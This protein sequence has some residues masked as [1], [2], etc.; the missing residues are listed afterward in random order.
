MAQNKNS[1]EIPHD[2]EVQPPR[3]GIP[4]T[5]SNKT[6]DWAK[7]IAMVLLPAF[8]ALYFGLAPF[9]ELPKAEA[10][11][12]TIVLLDAFIGTVLQI[13]NSR[14]NAQESFDGNIYL[15]EADE[16]GMQPMQVS[17]PIGALEQDEIRVKVH[18][19][20]K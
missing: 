1:P 15:Q 9:W 2:T 6:Y 19:P 10:V 8:G 14:Y 13:S 5:L 7:F 4:F 12:G 11:V 3:S 17:I 18:A 20:P 16:D